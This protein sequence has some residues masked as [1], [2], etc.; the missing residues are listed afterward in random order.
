MSKSSKSQPKS[1]KASKATAT[2]VTTTSAKEN[3]E[4]HLKLNT[5]KPLVPLIGRTYLINAILWSIG[6]S[7]DKEAKQMGVPAHVHAAAQTL[8]AQV[9]ALIPA[10]PVIIAA[11]VAATTA[12]SPATKVEAPAKPAATVEADRIA[13]AIMAD[14]DASEEDLDQLELAVQEKRL[15]RPVR[16]LANKHL[17]A[18]SRAA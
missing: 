5:G 15:S 7:Y 9:E 4:R 10:K 1:S 12:T 3:R 11:A 2:T 8:V 6:S 17:F 13:I 14:K 16:K 18:L